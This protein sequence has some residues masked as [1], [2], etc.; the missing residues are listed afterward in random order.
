M[1]QDIGLFDAIYTQRAIRQF[2]PEP[3]PDGLIR[4]LIESATKAPSGSNRQPWR[5]VIIRDAEVKLRI[6]EYYRQAWE[7]AYENQSSP[8]RPIQPRIRASAANLADRMHE[9]PVLILACIEHDGSPS[10]MGRGAS[11]YPAVQNLLLA[12]RGLGLGSVITTLHKRY[13]REVK[14]LLGIPE[15]VET[16]A[17]LPVG[18][19][20]DSSRYGSTLRDPGEEVTF[21]ERWEA[22]R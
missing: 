1:T 17:L 12:A 18:Y 21:W 20:A 10:S 2:K 3:V 15:N 13:E 8:P 22:R 9:V 19:P 6:G 4:K 16:A 14:E 11:I 5:F 7:A